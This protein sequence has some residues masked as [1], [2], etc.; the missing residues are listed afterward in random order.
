MF[1]LWPSRTYANIEL[2]MRCIKFRTITRLGKGRNSKEALGVF[3]TFVHWL[4][5]RLYS[6]FSVTLSFRK[7]A[8]L[9]WRSVS[10]TLERARGETKSPR[11]F[12]AAK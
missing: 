2:I 9:W 7:T 6:V 10:H 4:S 12:T 1:I 3:N 8:S 11:M 5:L